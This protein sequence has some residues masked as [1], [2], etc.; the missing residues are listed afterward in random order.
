MIM[1]SKTRPG[2]QGQL[3]PRFVADHVGCVV[4]DLGTSAMVADPA[5]SG[6]M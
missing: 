1:T 4:T 6:P 3:T 2:A 5:R